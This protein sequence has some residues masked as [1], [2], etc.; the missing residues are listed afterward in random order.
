MQRLSKAVQAPRNIFVR[1]TASGAWG[2]TNDC[3][4]TNVMM[5]KL[6]KTN[7]KLIAPCGINCRL[8]R[9]HIRNIKACPGC[10]DD[11]FKS[12]SCVACLI[13]NCEKLING[14]FKY[15]FSCD[16]LPCAQISHLEKRYTSKYG[17]SVL[18]NL[19]EIQTN[20]IRSFVRN[21]NKKWICSN[22][23]E[24]ICMH[25]VQCISCGHAWRE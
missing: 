3:Q 1:Y 18:H 9:A 6:K 4:T 16:E 14:C 11:I 13:K 12:K 5:T 8:C 22:C 25:K 23:G 7:S 10:R 15:C 2:M 19:K 17:V 24:I 21:E 20:G